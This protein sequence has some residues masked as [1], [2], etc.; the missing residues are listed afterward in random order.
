MPI[1]L[2]LNEF[3]M[4]HTAHQSQRRNQVAIDLEQP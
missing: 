4:R 3:R 2:R 1:G